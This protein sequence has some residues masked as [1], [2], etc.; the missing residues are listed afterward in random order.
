MAEYLKRYFSKEDIYLIDDQQVQE[1]M[2]SITNHQGDA[3]Q[4]QVFN[5][6]QRWQDHTMEERQSFQ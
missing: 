6:F 2:F 3:N 4:N 1:K 5:L